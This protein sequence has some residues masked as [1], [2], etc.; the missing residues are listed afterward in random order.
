MFDNLSG[1]HKLAAQAQEILNN[2]EE[3]YDLVGKRLALT[4]AILHKHFLNPTNTF[5]LAVVGN[6]NTGK[7]TFAYSIAKILELYQTPTTYV[8]LDIYTE[9]GRAISGEIKWE[10]RRKRDLEEIPLDE[11]LGSI[12]KFANAKPGIIIGDFPGRITNEFQGRRLKQ[13]NLALI[14]ALNEQDLSHWVNLCSK[15]EVGYIHAISKQSFTP[16]APIHPQVHSLH[17]QIQINTSLSPLLL[18]F[19]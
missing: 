10:E 14:L 7:T 16:E 17:R 3:V 1:A 11:T 5:R 12:D 13:A 2:P 8:D 9:S 6:P 4:S 18:G 15:N 19:Y